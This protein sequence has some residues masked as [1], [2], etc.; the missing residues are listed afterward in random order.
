ML[1]YTAKL[2]INSYSDSINKP[3]PDLFKPSLNFYYSF[4]IYISSS[5]VPDF[6]SDELIWHLSGLDYSCWESAP[7][8]LFDL[9][10]Q[11]KNI[12]L[13][14]FYYPTGTSSNPDHA[15]HQSAYTA[16]TT[17]ELNKVPHWLENITLSICYDEPIRG[18]V[19]LP[20]DKVKQLGDY[21]RPTFYWNDWWNLQEDSKPINKTDEKPN[22]KIHFKPQSLMN[23]CNNEMFS[24]VEDDDKAEDA[25]KRMFLEFDM[26]RRQRVC[27]FIKQQHKEEEA[28]LKY[29]Q[30]N[31]DPNYS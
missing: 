21:Y 16:R 5:N 12:Y 7:S 30:S 10:D 27:R 15:Q 3:V 18:E 4:D 8:F 2:R 22:L 25:M 24:S 23:A 26:K 20:L 17:I 28:I 14:A 1:F 29:L 19:P 6:Q 31:F 11:A 9:K 13:H